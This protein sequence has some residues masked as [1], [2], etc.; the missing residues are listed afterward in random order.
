M[1]VHDTLAH[2]VQYP[3]VHMYGHT[4]ACARTHMY[5]YI[6]ALRS[7]VGAILCE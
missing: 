3:R 5:I 2:A 7:A 1:C 6:S 4:H